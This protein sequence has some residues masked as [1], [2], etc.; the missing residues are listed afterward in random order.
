V[1]AFLWWVGAVEPSRVEAAKK[2]GTTLPS[3][4]SPLFA[5][6]PSALKTGAASLTAATLELLAPAR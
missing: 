4:H 6:H 1:P 2:E 3:L 5:P